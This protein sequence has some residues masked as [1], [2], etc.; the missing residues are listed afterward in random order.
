MTMNLR[1]SEDEKERA[2]RLRDV[3]EVLAIAQRVE[4]G[5]PSATTTCLRRALGHTIKQGS[6]QWVM[7]GVMR[8]EGLAPR[9]ERRPF[10]R[11]ESARVA[12]CSSRRRLVRRFARRVTRRYLAKLERFTRFEPD[13]DGVLETTRDHDPI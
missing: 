13:Q 5:H 10:L 12:R 7:N 2:S 8:F 11:A 4:L 1:R 9:T 3:E 6:S